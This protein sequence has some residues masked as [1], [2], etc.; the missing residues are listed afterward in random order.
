MNQSL[1]QIII[2]SLY[3][4]LHQITRVLHLYGNTHLSNLNEKVQMFKCANIY[5]PNCAILSLAWKIIQAPRL[6]IHKCAKIAVFCIGLGTLKSWGWH[7]I[8]G[9]SR[10]GLLY[11]RLDV[12]VGAKMHCICWIYSRER[13]NIHLLHIQ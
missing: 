1:K 3:L 6:K 4:L 9:W 2:C 7:I 5:I 11:H 10:G 8:K 12:E 13:T